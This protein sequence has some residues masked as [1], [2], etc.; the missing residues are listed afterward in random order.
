MVVTDIVIDS[1][2]ID[3][4]GKMGMNE[5][6]DNQIEGGGQQR[7]GLDSVLPCVD[8]ENA[9]SMYRCRKGVSATVGARRL[10]QLRATSD[11]SA[12]VQTPRSSR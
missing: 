8:E 6:Y 10:R 4:A 1:P 12:G 7:V 3:D 5:E 9:L 2:S 11:G